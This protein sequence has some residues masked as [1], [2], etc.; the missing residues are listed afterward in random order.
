MFPQI[1]RAKYPRA[2]KSLLLLIAIGMLILPAG[3]NSQEEIGSIEIIKTDTQNYPEINLQV[4]VRDGLGNAV[5]NLLDTDL[6]LRENDQEQTILAVEPVEAGLRLAFVIDP[7]DG[8]FNTGVTIKDLYQ[9]VLGDLEIFAFG[10]P[11]M[12]P[13]E[14]EVLILVQEGLT[15]NVIVPVSSDPETLF[16]SF[17]SYLPPSSTAVEPPEFGDFT[18]L[19][20]NAALKEIKLARPGFVDRKEAI[21]LYTPGMRAD[22]VDVAEEALSLGIPIHIILTRPARMRYWDEA[23]RPLAEATGG[24]FLETYESDDSEILFER[25][26][27][28][29][30]QYIVTYQ[31]ALM[32]ADDRQVTLET[33]GGAL[34]SSSYNF[35]V[36]P[37]LVEITAPQTDLI[38]R[39]GFEGQEA[40]LDAEPTF[41]IV[42]AQV[43]WPDGMPREVQFAR[44]LVDG[45]SVGDGPVVNNQT[46]IP[47]D[48]RAY[49]S[50]SWTP[51]SL[52][53]EMVD[54]FGLVGQSSPAIVAIRYVPPTSTGFNPTENMIVYISGGIALLS[55]GLALFLFVNRS[56]GGSAFENAREGII[57]FVERVTGRRT[58]LVARAFLVPLE[59][60]DE[61]PSKS[62]EIYGTTALGRSRRHADLLFHIGEEDSP[63]SR[64][65]CTVLDEDDHF[66]IRDEDSSNGTFVNGE[67]LI[68]L[69]AIML[70]DGDVIDL[71]PLERGGISLMF[72]LARLDGEE[73]GRDDKIN[74]TRP[75]SIISPTQD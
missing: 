29:R 30:T 39:E 53:V 43:T 13:E 55:L 72:Q 70:H 44:L 71:A 16:S 46:E 20:L 23:L 21:L 10:R 7:G 64:L 62:Y 8:S 42:T 37:P 58:A 12:L 5:E 65:Q 17:E 31:T 75:R 61:P 51:A 74:M 63:I 57:D 67:Q 69:Q 2:W 1:R 33:L 56:R 27:S 59:G 48:L 54:E 52:T 47:W 28:Q 3:A 35:D 15:T 50:E 49:Q 11:W 34:A 14:D 24:E 18:R 68:P 9:K 4:L 25:L 22:L 73:R 40:A 38:S 60:F 41:V 45:I 32:T 6:I 26:A 19:A 36:L 66:S